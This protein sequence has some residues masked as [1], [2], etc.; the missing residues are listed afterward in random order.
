MGIVEFLKQTGVDF[1][2]TEHSPTFTAQRMAS[3]EHEPGKNVAKPVIVKA[4]NEYLMCVL[5]AS[6]KVDLLALKEKLGAKTVELAE[7]KEIAKLFADCELGAQP[8]FGN[9][10]NMTVIM[11]KA[12]EVDEHIIFQ[13]GTH[14]KAIRMSMSDYEKLVQPKI[15]RFSYQTK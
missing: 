14:D 12:L 4:D 11:D 6:H 9:L 1:Q 8:P 2:I 13:G 5:A 3:V 7:E 10:Y 15:L